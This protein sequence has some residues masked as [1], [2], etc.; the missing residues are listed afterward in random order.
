MQDILSLRDE[1]ISAATDRRALVL[2]RWLLVLTTAALLLG[3]Q[4]YQSVSMAAIGLVIVFAGTNLA[5]QFYWD[6]FES[7]QRAE[8]LLATFDTL[9]LSSAI[10]LA[11]IA[12][13]ELL[14]LT[15]GY[16]AVVSA[17]IAASPIRT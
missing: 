6:R 1:E 5:L 16:I 4:L 9:F 8:L 7:R 15:L 14:V 17:N 3:A 12:T 10:F 2:L 11:G 13:S